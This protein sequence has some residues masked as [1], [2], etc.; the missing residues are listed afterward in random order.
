VELR[1]TV[2]GRAPL[3]GTIESRAAH[4][5]YAPGMELRILAPSAIPATPN[6]HVLDAKTGSAVDGIETISLV[7]SPHSWIVARVVYRETRIGEAKEDPDAKIRELDLT[8]LS[9]PTV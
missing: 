8:A 4:V 6:L 3:P 9:E 1:D 2:A 7:L 5:R